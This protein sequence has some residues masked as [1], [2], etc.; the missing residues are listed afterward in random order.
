MHPLSQEAIVLGGVDYSDSSRIIW[1][2]TPDFGRQ[3]L[4]VKGARRA[5]SKFQG[6][7]ETFNLVQLIYRK[8]GG[9][10]TLYVLREADLQRACTGFRTNLEAFWAASRAVE[11]VKVLAP[12]EHECRALFEL[13]KEFL[14][15]ADSAEQGEGHTKPL[16]GAFCW[17]LVSLAGLAP[18]LVECV[19]CGKKLNRTSCYRFST[20]QGGVLCSKCQGQPGGGGEAV[21]ASRGGGLWFELSYPVL[22]FIYRSSRKF[23]GSV[24]ELTPLT[25]GELEVVDK[26]ARTYLA[27]HLG[28]HTAFRAG[29]AEM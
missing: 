10:G 20:S 6:V 22:R 2:L 21:P 7:L 27:Q 28:D 15:L 4:M 1:V 17:R 13:L 14:A 26:L 11:L 24:D 23:P 5:R 29:V 9:G 8:R 25:D 19:Y 18:R 3:S 16:L 12:E